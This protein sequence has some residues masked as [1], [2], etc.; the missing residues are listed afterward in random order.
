MKRRN[1]DE[2]RSELKIHMKSNTLDFIFGVFVCV[3]VANKLTRIA[4]LIEHSFGLNRY[5][6]V[7]AAVAAKRISQSIEFIIP[8]VNPC[9]NARVRHI[10]RDLHE[11][12]H[13]HKIGKPPIASAVTNT[14]HT[15]MLSMLCDTCS[16]RD[17]T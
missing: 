2:T 8:K 12:T 10:E 11:H 1:T 13:T 14:I 17:A 15:R 4:T 16:V 7:A 3:C 9:H 6:H 5:E